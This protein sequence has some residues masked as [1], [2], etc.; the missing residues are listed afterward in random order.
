VA[1]RARRG[2]HA[3]AAGSA[4]TTT[5]GLP[6]KP[7]DCPPELVE[8]MGA[9]IIAKVERRWPVRM[10]KLGPYLVWTGPT[11]NN[12]GIY[13]WM[14]DAAIKRMDVSHRVVWRRGCLGRS[15]WGR[16]VRRSRST[17]AARSRCVS[18]PITCNC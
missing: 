3:A 4:A 16:T 12:K 15:R 18:G 13:G 8:K 17:T 14:Y 11:Q 9:D 6:A 10:H 2:P 7:P 1:A 5:A